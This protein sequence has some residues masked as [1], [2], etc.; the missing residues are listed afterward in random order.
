M[1]DWLT[2]PR[3]CTGV[4]PAW[5]QPHVMAAQFCGRSAKP[6]RPGAATAAAVLG[7]V[8]GSLGTLLALGVIAVICTLAS[9]RTRSW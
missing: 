6:R 5:A 8:S 9:K 1:R 7:I 2:V 3:P 4:N